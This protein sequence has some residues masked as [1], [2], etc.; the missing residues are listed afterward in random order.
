MLLDFPIFHI[1]QNCDFVGKVLV[2]KCRE[3]TQFLKDLVWAKQ[4]SF[5][6]HDNLKAASLQSLVYSWPFDQSY[7]CVCYACA[8]CVVPGSGARIWH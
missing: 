5:V 1:T 4:N 2:L 3:I 6:G 8:V 7:D